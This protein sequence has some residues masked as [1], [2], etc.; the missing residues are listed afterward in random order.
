M[1]EQH[2]RICTVDVHVLQLILCYQWPSWSKYNINVQYRTKD[3]CMWY[4][5]QLVLHFIR[6]IPG[7]CIQQVT[8]TKTSL[9]PVSTDLIAVCC[10]SKT[11]YSHC[12]DNWKTI[13]L[14]LIKTKLQLCNILTERKSK[15]QSKYSQRYICLTLFSLTN[16]ALDLNNYLKKNLKPEH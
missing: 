7:V 4:I 1:V 5:V 9:P 3:H 6:L 10:L 12:L 13:T 14:I 11:F 15:K 2:G 8:C 16:I